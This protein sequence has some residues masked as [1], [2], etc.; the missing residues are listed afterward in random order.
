MLFALYPRM[1]RG[2]R[3]IMGLFGLKPNEKEQA[4]EGGEI[5]TVK[6]IDDFVKNIANVVYRIP[7]AIVRLEEAI[8]EEMAP[9][10]QRSGGSETSS[11]EASDSEDRRSYASDD[12]EF[13]DNNYFARGMDSNYRQETA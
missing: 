13:M 6:D 12:F 10:L 11:Q 1:G 7:D 4:S 3:H 8:E 5:L 9:I 2:V